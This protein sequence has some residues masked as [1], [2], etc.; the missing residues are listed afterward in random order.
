MLAIM[1][2]ALR[3]DD[4]ALLL[5]IQRGRSLQ[6]AALKLGCDA[7]TVS[8]RLR[9]FEST[10]DAR[11]FDRTPDG[12]VATNLAHRLMPH[13]ERAEAAVLDARTEAEGTDTR[14]DG[15][16]RVA[17]AGG[18][19][20]YM[21]APNIHEFHDQHPK[22]R[23]EFLVSTRLV[24]LTRREADIAVRFVRPTQGD[25][26]CKRLP[27]A[28]ESCVVAT[29]TYARSR[30]EGEPLRWIGWVPEYQS[31]PDAQQLRAITDE[32]P[33]IAC[34]DMVTMVEC[35]RGNAGAMLLPR[36]ILGSY[37]ELTEIP[38]Y[39]VPPNESSIWLVCHRALRDVPR[40]SATWQWLEALTERT[41]R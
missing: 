11:L 15:T 38:G 24:D 30:K 19:A 4:L 35:L 39:D 33:T 26:V 36:S 14:L 34:N 2:D 29:K 3:W 5:A 16:V 20:A 17:V 12:L 9:A 40:I 13:A 8:R 31:L 7:S 27:T 28:G 25:L 18:Y 21:L 6:A 22:I 37:S 1:Q 32:A 41:L 10:L 23:L